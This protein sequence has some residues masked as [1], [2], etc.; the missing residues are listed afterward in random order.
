MNAAVEPM[1]ISD[2]RIVMRVVARTAL[3]GILDVGLTFEKNS[4]KGRALSRAKAK[5]WREQVARILIALQ[6]SRIRMMHAR[7]VV[8]LLE[9]VA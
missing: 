9:P 4:E 3:T 1:L 8:A 7:P 2:R 6:T 5:A